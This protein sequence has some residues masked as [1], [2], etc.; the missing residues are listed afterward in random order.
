MARRKMAKQTYVY[1]VVYDLGELGNKK[2]PKWKRTLFVNVEMGTVF[3]STTYLNDEIVDS[4]PLGTDDSILINNRLYVD[5]DS[6][7]ALFYTADIS[8]DETEIS[9]VEYLDVIKEK[10]LTA[11]EVAED[12]GDLR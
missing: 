7:K 2:T 1:P 4:I 10:A 6:Y 12:E 8:D 11:A 3:V 9:I 5:I